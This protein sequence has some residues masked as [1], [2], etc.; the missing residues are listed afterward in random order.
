MEDGVV[1]HTWSSLQSRFDLIIKFTLAIATYQDADIGDADFLHKVEF[2]LESFAVTA[3]T[4]TGQDCSVPEVCADITVFLVS[5]VEMSV[6][7]FYKL[8]WSLFAS[9]VLLFRHSQ[10]YA[11]DTAND[12][13][14]QS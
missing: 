4:F 3:Q 8:N 9:L 2:L 5:D 14:Y 11:Y 1:I 7:D 10:K 12:N 6:F 13:D